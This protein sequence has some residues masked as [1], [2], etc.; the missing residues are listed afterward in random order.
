MQHLGKFHYV[1][2]NVVFYVFNIIT[3][4]P[5]NRSAAQGDATCYV[6]FDYLF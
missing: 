6:D 2:E 1:R 3:K 4:L 5:E